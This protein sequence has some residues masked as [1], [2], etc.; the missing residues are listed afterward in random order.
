MVSEI[1]QFAVSGKRRLIQKCGFDLYETN[2]GIFI[3][4]DQANITSAM[5]K[6]LGHRDHLIRTKSD[7]PLISFV[8]R[9][10]ED[11]IIIIIIIKLLYSNKK[12]SIK[13]L[14]V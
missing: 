11:L 14:N 12:R 6:R 5:T 4:I 2:E 7:I 8:A 13:I 3:R 1:G 10:L 9:E